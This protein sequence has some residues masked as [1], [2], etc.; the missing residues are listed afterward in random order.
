MAKALEFPAERIAKGVHS[1]TPEMGQ[2]KVS[3]QMQAS[4]SHGGGY[5]VVSP[6]ELKGRGIKHYQSEGNRHIYYMTDLAFDKLKSQ[7]SISMERLL[8]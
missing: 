7:Y 3:C 4:L 5:R 2:R 8:D 6:I 1:Y